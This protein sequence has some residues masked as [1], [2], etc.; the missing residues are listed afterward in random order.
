MKQVYSDLKYLQTIHAA[1]ICKMQI[2]PREWLASDPVVDFETG[3]VLQAVSLKANKFWLA[4]ELTPPSYDYNE[5]LKNAK[6][7]DY[8]EISASGLLNTFNSAL[9]QVFE[10]IRYS[11]LVAIIYDRNK[12]RKLVGNSGAGMR[13]ALVHTHTN[14][15]AGVESLAVTLAAEFEDLPPF[16]NPDNT[17]DILGNFLIDAN[18]N[19]LL[20]E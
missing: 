2:T 3:E 16:Y 19:Y 8:Y 10:T 17:P 6:S 20:V 9:Q 5:T 7:G 18:G 14:T 11:E 15:P 12:R 13:L 1:G 4:V